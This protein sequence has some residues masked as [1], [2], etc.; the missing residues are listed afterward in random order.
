MEQMLD[1]GLT[2]HIDG[3]YRYAMALARNP[4]VAADLVQETYVRAL[5]ARKGLRAG[6]N[7]KSWLFTILRN[8]WL[9]Q[10]RHS[11]TAPQVND[12][13]ADD[14]RTPRAAE[15]SNPHAA[16][17]SKLERERVREAIQQLPDEFREII[18][19]R[20]F[21]ELSYQ[22]IATVLDCPPGTVMSR[23]ARARS[24]L[25]GLL[26]ISKEPGANEQRPPDED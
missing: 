25:R 2:C 12:L 19:L 7:V 26:S 22:E 13:D 10:L 23:L 21:E 9:N 18:V 8:V 20:A 11:R 4:A 1:T 6:S 5:P 16:Y 3:L 14:S 24:K 17:I 15:A